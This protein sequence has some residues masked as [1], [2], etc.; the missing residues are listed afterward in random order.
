[1]Y[2]Q[3]ESYHQYNP[4]NPHHQNHYGQTS[5]HQQMDSNHHKKQMHELCNNYH[6]YFM[7]FQTMEGDT[8]EGIIE[9][10]DEDS[11]II[12]IPSGDLERVE[13]T[14]R[15]Y[16]FGYGGYPRRFRRFRRHRFPFLLLR[17]LFFPY[18]YY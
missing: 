17:S 2:Q 15:Q 4:H 9:D 18:Y 14:E 6:L 16:G 7:Q 13:E 11:V 1:M 12:L 5:G 3:P 8:F 10:I